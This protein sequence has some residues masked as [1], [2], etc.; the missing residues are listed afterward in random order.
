[1]GLS[2]MIMLMRSVK[3]KYLN[4]ASLSNDR[5]ADTS[6]A[7]HSPLRTRLVHPSLAFCPDVPSGK[8]RF[9]K[10][11]GI[12]REPHRI[13]GADVLLFEGLKRVR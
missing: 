13:R 1:M 6:A 4:L 5:S 3:I 9:A 12:G 7:P 10:F 11:Y 2:V 8:C